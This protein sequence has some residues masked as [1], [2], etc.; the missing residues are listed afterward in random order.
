MFKLLSFYII[1]TVVLATA[2]TFAIIS[3]IFFLMTM[4]AEFKYMGEG[5]YG[6]VQAV[7]YVIL[8]LPTL[9]YQFSPMMILIGSILGLS[10]LSTHREL[11]V[12][13]AAGF[14]MWKIMQSVFMAALIITLGFSV[15]GEW[16][17][18]RLSYKAEMRK[19]AAQ[20]NGQ[21]VVT[22]SGLWL[23][24]RNNFIHVKQVV[25][26]QLLQGVT[27]YQFDDQDHLIATYY[28][29]RLEY[30]AN[31]WLMKDVSI[32]R[33]TANGVSNSTTRLSAPW[34]VKFN[35]NLLNIGL[36][37]LNEMPLTKIAMFAHYLKKNGLQASQY[38]YEL[39]RRLFQPFSSLVMIFLAI[40]CVLGAFRSHSL[41]WR[42][43]VGI[44][45]GFAFYILNTFVGQLC[46]V[47]QLPVT[48]SALVPPLIFAALGLILSKRML[49]H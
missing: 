37:D 19:E 4:L 46:I 32:T 20:N 26:R 5:D 49:R 2:L 41:G 15:F 10:M 9:L 16:L 48:V 18:P 1:K 8:H 22:A 47:Y 29:K 25:G 44:M 28:A 40:P 42:V 30:Q 33:F 17:A 23:H 7:T 35:P 24:A 3:S 12:M 43:V 14:S 11:I 39:W 34:D 31:Q 38:Q 6:F 36:I 21:A 27:R 45:I 13:R